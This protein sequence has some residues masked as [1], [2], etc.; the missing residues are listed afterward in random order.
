MRGFDPLRVTLIFVDGGRLLR[1][2]LVGVAIANDRFVVIRATK[3]YFIFLSSLGD[4]GLYGL[5]PLK[6]VI[7]SFRAY[8]SRL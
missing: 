8:R 6:L 5:A 1:S 4:C 7:D 3:R 2:A